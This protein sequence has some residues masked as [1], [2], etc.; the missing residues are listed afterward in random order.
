MQRPRPGPG[1]SPE[2]RDRLA[3]VQERVQR[4]ETDSPWS[5]LSMQRPRPGPGESPE[6]RDRLA[7]ELTE[8]A[9]APP[10]SRRE[11]PTRPGPG[12]SPEKRDRLA[13]VQ[14][15]V[16]RERDRLA[17]VQERVQRRETDSPRSRRESR[18]ERPTRPGPRESP[19]KR[20]RLAPVQERVQR[21][22]TDSPRSR[23]ESREERPTGPGPG[24]SPEKRDRLAPVQERVQRRETDSPRSRRESREER[25]TRPSRAMKIEG[26]GSCLMMVGIPAG[27]STPYVQ[28]SLGADVEPLHFYCTEYSGGF[29]S[30]GFKPRSGL[31]TGTGYKSNFRPALYYRAC[32][33]RLDNPTFGLSILGNYSSVTHKNFLP[34]RN[35]DGTEPLPK[36]TESRGSGFTR[37]PGLTIPGQHNTVSWKEDTGFTEGS[38]LE[39]IIYHPPSNH[40]GELSWFP[41]LSLSLSLSL[42][43]G[44]ET[45][46]RLADRQ[47]RNTGF[48]REG[49][50]PVTSSN[51]NQHSDPPGCFVTVSQLSH[52]PLAL[53]HPPSHPQLL[54]RVTVG[55][56][57]LSG[58]SENTPAHVTQSCDPAASQRFLTHYSIKF[59][60]KTLVGTDREGWTRGGIQ[61]QNPNSYTFNNQRQRLG[62]ERPARESLHTLHPH[63]ARTIQKLSP[64]LDDHTHRYRIRP[65]QFAV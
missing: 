62:R 41:P 22:E 36:N 26:E 24:E 65:L 42:S 64:P 16:Q 61:R 45:L 13:P 6:K 43:Q 7:M 3:P 55:S 27:K 44:G 25:P 17:P 40:W 48:T 28:T 58:Y 12:E 30:S 49:V 15:R 50:A 14:E 53:S 57:E 59:C 10:R 35:P 23:R 1:E 31:H 32:L 21:R 52:G 4:R 54:G 47:E 2:K 9:E 38:N 18:E 39:P 34:S 8:H 46:P 29:G 51:R 20:D 5:S 60:D 63:Q 37:E 33:D 11:S 19:E 56:K